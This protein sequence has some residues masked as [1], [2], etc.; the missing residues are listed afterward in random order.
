[1]SIYT[2][3]QYN[4]RCLLFRCQKEITPKSI[5]GDIFF[6][7]ARKKSTPKPTLYDT[8]TMTSTGWRRTLAQVGIGSNIYVLQENRGK[9]DIWLAVI[10]IAEAAVQMDVSSPSQSCFSLA[11]FCPCCLFLRANVV[12][13]FRHMSVF[14]SRRHRPVNLVNIDAKYK[15][16]K[17]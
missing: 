14:V 4:R 9:G 2:S 3:I 15:A 13:F 6:F 10:N 11:E 7:V 5:T 12:V 1:M 17:H 8:F 16:I